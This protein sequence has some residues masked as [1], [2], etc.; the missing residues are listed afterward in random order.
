M[1]FC[2]KFEIG[3]VVLKNKIFKNFVN[4]FLLFRNYLP[5]EQ[6]RGTNL[7][8]L[9]SPSPKDALRHVWLKLVRGP[10]Q[11]IR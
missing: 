7:N 8:K 4:L 1:M 11:R 10:A 6:D 5:L 3:T 9:E 2:A